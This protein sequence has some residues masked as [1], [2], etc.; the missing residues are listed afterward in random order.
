MHKLSHES[1]GVWIAHSHTPV[2]ATESASGTR[3]VVVGV[4]GGD[5]T[6]FG[7]LV[8]ALE[9]PYFILYV[10]HTPRGEGPAGRYQSPPLTLSEF[11]SFLER[12]SSFLSADARHD[13]WTHS[14]AD[15]AT[16]VWERH[17]LIYGYGAVEQFISILR[18][19]GFDS[20]N[21]DASFPHQHHYREEFDADAAS[22]LS[23]YDWSYSP[24]Q[25]EDEQ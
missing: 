13:I 14:P 8:T 23:A 9:P 22:I 3:R 6:V 17:N 18:T 25:P 10:L 7:S 1:D 16:V 20:G 24:L 2:F 11:R 4:P 5:Y 21:A 19:L 12:Y 15:N